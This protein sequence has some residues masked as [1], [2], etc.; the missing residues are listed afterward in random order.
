[1]SFRSR[2]QEQDCWA[3]RSLVSFS[4]LLWFTASTYR[5]AIEVT[6]HN[7]Y[8]SRSLFRTCL[9]TYKLKALA[10]LV[11]FLYLQLSVYSLWSWDVCAARLLVRR[12][13]IQGLILFRIFTYLHSVQTW[14][15]AHQPTPVG[16]RGLFLQGKAAME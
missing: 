13:R 7:S 5:F 1:V 15:W 9:P 11:R 3:L 2:S 12:P 16:T 8:R 14:R 4:P 6:H 10:H